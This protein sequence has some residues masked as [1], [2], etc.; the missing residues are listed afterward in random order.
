VA[1]SLPPLYGIFAFSANDIWLSA[2]DPI[3]GD[4]NNWTLYDV[5]LITGFDTLSLE[6]CWGTDS[7]QMYFVG[8]HG[9]FIHYS[10]GTWTKIE[11]GTTLDI[12]DIYGAYKPYSLFGKWE[13]L[14]VA[15]S[16]TPSRQERKLLRIYPVTNAVSPVDTS[17]LAIDVQSV[18]FVPNQ[19]YYVVGSGIHQ[20]S[21]LSDPR[22]SVYSPGEVTS[23]ASSKIRGQGTN[24]V[25]VVGSFCEVVHFNGS[26]WYN[27][28]NEIPFANGAFGGVDIKG[29]TAVIVGYIDQQAVAIVGKRQ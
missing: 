10:N 29:N 3:H 23:Y 19:H 4:G 13:I 7:S 26:T 24:D 15:S 11:S 27:Y 28:R 1:T 22:W 20:K 2:G 14:A 5:R 6:K 25:F 21:S 17:G 16:Y 9:S 12:H 8:L 18:W